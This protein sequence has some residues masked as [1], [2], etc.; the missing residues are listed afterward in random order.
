MKLII[1]GSRHLDVPPAFVY[2]CAYKWGIAE[3]VTEVVC[4]EA[5]GV[6]QSGKELALMNQSPLK[7]FPANWKE[8]G[9]AAGPIRNRE[10]AEYADALLLIWDGVSPGSKNMKKTM[11]ELG[12][13]VYEYIVKRVV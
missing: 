8:H 5:L 7:T 12:K 2:F 3:D 13:P 9:K 4:G 1:A 10:M 6:D 11:E